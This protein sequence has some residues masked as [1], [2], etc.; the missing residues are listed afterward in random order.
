MLL[1]PSYSLQ[2]ELCFST[3]DSSTDNARR[4]MQN[5]TI[6]TQMGLKVILI[7]G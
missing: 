4:S 3:S 5:K 6:K 1:K 7:K 2:V